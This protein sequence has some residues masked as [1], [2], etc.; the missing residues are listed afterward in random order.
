M[1][2]NK[3]EKK[4]ISQ[5]EGAPQPL[6]KAE[7]EMLR[8]AM[9]AREVDRS[10]L[11]SHDNSLKA[12]ICRFIKENKIFTAVCAVLAICVVILIV[13]LSVMAISSLSR[14]RVNKDDFTLMIGDEVLTVKY[15]T[16]MRDDILYVDM[17]KIAAYAELTKTGTKSNVKFTAAENQYLRFENDSEFA[18]INGAMVEMSGKATVNAEVCDIPLEFLMTVL[19]KNNGLKITLDT[20]TNTIKI[21][22]RMYITEDE[23][24]YLPVEILFYSESFNIIQAIKRPDEEEPPQY[25]YLIAIDKYHSNI[26]PENTEEYLLL[27]N[28]ESILGEDY[29]PSDLT[30]LE[31]RVASGRT[32]YLREDAALS[33]Y[34]MM[35]EMNAAGI[36]DVYVTSAYRSYIYQVGLFERYVNKHMNG[37]CHVRKPRRLPLNTPP[38]Q[39]P[40]SIRRDCVLTL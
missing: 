5:G 18:V 33:L 11:P 40:A 3:K 34:A 8:A 19:G 35:E 10:T 39:G 22:R 17:Y 28:K 7:I 13:L 1:K 23:D 14:N 25:E 6:S 32:M 12:K 15:K 26:D 20:D 4:P 30:Q 21:K 37:E 27:A 24:A 2:K 31:C 29:A 16:A 38:A 36:T 9:D